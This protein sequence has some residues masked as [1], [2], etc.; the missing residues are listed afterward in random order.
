MNKILIGSHALKYWYPDFPR[1]PKDI[2][3]ITQE[4]QRK[5]NEE[6]HWNNAF[7]LISEKKGIFPMYSSNAST[8]VATPDILYTIKCSHSFWDIHWGKNLRDIV[9]MQ[10]K[11]CE[12]IEEIF[13]ALYA[14]WEIRHSKKR[15][16]LA[17]K[18]EDFFKSSVKR[19]Y[20]HDSIHEAVAFYDRPMFERVKTDKSKAFV[21]KQKFLDLSVEDK[22]KLCLEEIHVIALERFLIP[23]E[24]KMNPKSARLEAAKI[25]I[26]SAAKGWWP[27]YIVENFRRL[28][29]LNDDNSFVDKFKEKEEQGLIKLNE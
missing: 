26:T 7:K 13:N 16:F 18:N 23:R 19:K 4:T 1:V 22:D 10:S 11:G 20:I 17:E 21:S 28:H 29:E 25:L 24:F 15:A 27:R 9:F 12:I 14:E 6:F 3:Y 5:K 8:Y 2:D